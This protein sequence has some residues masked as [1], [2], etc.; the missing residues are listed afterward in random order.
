[1]KRERKKKDILNMATWRKGQGGPM[2]HSR[3]YFV[4]LIFSF[5]WKIRSMHTQS[6]YSS[7]SHCS[8]VMLSHLT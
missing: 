2:I 3:Q 6:R 8:I 7:T 4:D 1:M 5:K